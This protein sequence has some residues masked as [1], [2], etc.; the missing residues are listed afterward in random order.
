MRKIIQDD[1]LRLRNPAHLAAKLAAL[2]PG[3]QIPYVVTGS[4]PIDRALLGYAWERYEEGTVELV[5][6]RQE[7]GQLVYWAIGRHH[8]RPIREEK[9]HRSSL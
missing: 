4:D 6:E 5:Q 3:E 8:I 9:V 1:L 7:T 2:E